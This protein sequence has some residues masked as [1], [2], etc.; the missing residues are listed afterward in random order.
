MMKHYTVHAFPKYYGTDSFDPSVLD[1]ETLSGLLV[2]EA[3]RSY[4]V[5]DERE[6]RLY[7]VEAE[8]CVEAVKKYID[9]IYGMMTVYEWDEAEG[10]WN[11]TN[12]ADWA[13]NHFNYEIDR[14]DWD[15]VVEG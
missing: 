13:G 15:E 1:I 9:F 4:T 10:G 3:G 11:P 12:Q 7:C 2:V 6:H 14:L 8:S 5:V